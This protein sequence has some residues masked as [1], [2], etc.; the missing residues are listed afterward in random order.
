MTGPLSEAVAAAEEIIDAA[1][2]SRHVDPE[3]VKACAKRVSECLRQA[4]PPYGRPQGDD[5]RS[6]QIADALRSLRE[7]CEDWGKIYDKPHIPTVDRLQL[8]EYADDLGV[9]LSWVRAHVEPTD[10]WAWGDFQHI[11]RD[12]APS[13]GD[14]EKVEIG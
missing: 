10:I 9:P 13:I 6:D 4:E 14:D 5:D 7:R 3:V 12:R 11:K 2:G 8:L 1:H